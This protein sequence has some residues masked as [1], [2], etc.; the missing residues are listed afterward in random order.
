MANVSSLLG[1]PRDSRS[2]AEDKRF[3]LPDTRLGLEFEFEKVENNKLPKDSPEAMLWEFHRDDSLK[4]KGAEYVFASPLFGKDAYDAIK[5]LMEYSAASKWVSSLRTGIHVHVDI[6]DLEVDQ[7]VG[8]IILY[9]IVEPV[10][11]EWIGDNREHN[12]HCVPYYRAD[13]SLMEAISIVQKAHSDVKFGTQ[14]CLKTA[15]LYSRYS[16]MN[17]KALADHGSVEFR[18]MKTTFD[19]NRVITWINMLMCIKSCAFKVPTSD[20]A[21]VKMAEAMQPEDFLTYIFGD[22][23]KQLITPRTEAL[24]KEFGIPTARDLALHSDSS[25]KWRLIEYPKGVNRGFTRYMNNKK[26]LLPA[27]AAH[28]NATFYGTAGGL[29]PIQVGDWAINA[30]VDVPQHLDI[31]AETNRR[32]RQRDRAIREIEAANMRIRPRPNR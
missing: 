13:D 28:S 32:Q 21:I 24:L 26:D 20:G 12:N 10:L 1:K 29:A 3:V 22:Y 9:S 2:F 27:S 17:L 8:M 15:E 31:D 16:A 25:S 6:R 5:W 18:H 30:A 11:F 7:L 14:S 19:F 4:D 23:A